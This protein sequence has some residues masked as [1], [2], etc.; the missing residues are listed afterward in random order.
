L[1]K[2][3]FTGAPLQ[4]YAIL[5]LDDGD[6]LSRRH[7]ASGSVVGLRPTC[8]RGRHR[9]PA[10]TTQAWIGRQLLEGL[11]LNPERPD[12]DG[13]HGLGDERATCATFI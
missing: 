2:A 10:F 12:G 4:D 6:L 13:V 3:S 9:C 8:G 1:A 7:L 5:E 11:P